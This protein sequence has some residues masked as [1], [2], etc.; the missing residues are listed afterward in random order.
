MKTKNDDSKQVDNLIHC[1][2]L[3]LHDRDDVFFTTSF[4]YQSEL[5]F[6]LLEKLNKKPKCLFIKSPLIKGD[7]EKH[8]SYILEKYCPDFYEVDR[9]DW[10]LERLN[11][12]SFL[13]LDQE[14]RDS[15]CKSLKRGPLIDFIETYDC[16]VWVSGIRRDQTDS[17]SSIKYIETTDLGVIKVSPM[18]SWS[19]FEVKNIMKLL[20]LKTNLSYQDLCKFNESR[21]CGL[22]L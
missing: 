17:R 15:I 14:T 11:G 2:E 21:E 12:E 10:I 16:G 1:I 6:Y 3:T 9:N 13:N 22:H 19:N 18:F 20:D 4:G 8:K 5:L 7:I